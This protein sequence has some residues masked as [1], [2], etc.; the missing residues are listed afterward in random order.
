ME[1]ERIRLINWSSLQVFAAS[2][3]AAS[4]P[5]NFHADAVLYQ[6]SRG[7]GNPSLDQVS[8][9]GYPESVRRRLSL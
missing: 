8:P 1:G 4:G 5:R 3:G 2:R 9:S 7:S 6:G